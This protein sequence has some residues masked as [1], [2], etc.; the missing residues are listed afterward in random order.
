MQGTKASSEE[1][2]LYPT[3]RIQ[4]SRKDTWAIIGNSTD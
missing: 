4:S 3:F 1:D 2:L